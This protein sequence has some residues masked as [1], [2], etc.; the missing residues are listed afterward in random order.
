[1]KGNE[2]IPYDNESKEENPILL[3]LDSSFNSPHWS[4]HTLF[5]KT[6]EHY[7]Q[8]YPN[9]SINVLLL[10]SI[11]NAHKEVK[12]ASFDKRMKMMCIMSRLLNKYFES[13]CSYVGLT[14]FGEFVDKDAII[15]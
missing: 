6:N 11:R 13:L 12:P 4:H 8:L 15:E 7:S 2:R 10:L 3:V 1:M 5:K 14:V 9:K